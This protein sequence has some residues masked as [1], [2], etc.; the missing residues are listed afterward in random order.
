MKKLTNMQVSIH[1]VDLFCGAGG[2]THGLKQAGVNICLGV[3]I[4]PL[5]CYPYEANNKAKFLQKSVVELTAKEIS[6]CFTNKSV[7]LLAGCAP[8]Q[9]FSKYNQKATD[10]DSRWWLLNHF[11]RLIREASPQL[12]TMENV[13]GLIDRSV[14]KKFVQEIRR[15]GYIVDY[16]VV[17]CADYGLAQHRNRL[18]L[19][20]SRLGP[21][22]LLTPKEFGRRP[23]TVRQAIGKLEAIKAGGGSIKDPLHRSASLSPLNMRRIQVAVQNGTWR[24]WPKQLVCSCHRKVT[25]KTYP[26]VYG[27]MSWDKPAP[28]ITTQFFGFGNGRFGHP[29]AHR[30]IS[31]REGAV[32]Q[33]FP[34]SYKFVRKSDDINFSSIGR[35][36]GNAVPVILGQLIGRSLIR[37]VQ[38]NKHQGCLINGERLK[39]CL[40]NKS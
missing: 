9:T 2:L 10:E 14:F 29:E 26:S 23:K 25:G 40:N 33:S 16:Q 30:A 20:A 17:N 36:I 38:Y 5:C 32:L 6:A 28:T 4:D 27:R 21:I 8:C 39:T 12:I 19:L 7:S 37:H 34:K 24:D 1:G 11:G 31:L 35:L 22:R 3:D 15:L 13:P 18:V